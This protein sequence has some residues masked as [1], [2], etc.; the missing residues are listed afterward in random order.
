MRGDRE[1]CSYD[2]QV[3]NETTGEVRVVV[4]ECDFDVDAQVAA[5]HRLFHE[6]G[7]RRA[8]AMKPQTALAAS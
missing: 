2:I 6:E 7:W 5:L 3:R 1:V 8:T 4:V